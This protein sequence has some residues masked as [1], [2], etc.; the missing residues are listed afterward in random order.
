MT[1]VKSQTMEEAVGFNTFT[2]IEREPLLLEIVLEDVGDL[3][4]IDKPIGVHAYF[5]ISY[6]WDIYKRKY[7]GFTEGTGQY[8]VHTNSL[9][10]PFS[11]SDM[12]NV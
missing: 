3:S 7:K 6:K 5:P 12:P 1:S 10:I 11:F 8:K 9:I 4:T 2:I